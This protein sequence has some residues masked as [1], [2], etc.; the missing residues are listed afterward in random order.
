[1]ENHMWIIILSILFILFV[2]TVTWLSYSLG[3]TKTENPIKSGVIGFLLSFLPP[4][5]LIYLII[6]SLKEEVTTV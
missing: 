6:L 4:I 2:S 3:F 5:G 1:M